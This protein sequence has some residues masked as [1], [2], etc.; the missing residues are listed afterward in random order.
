MHSCEVLRGE[1]LLAYDSAAAENEV[2]HARGHSGLLVDLHQVVVRENG[3]GR[4]LPYHGV[5]HQHGGHREVG[6]NGCEVE[7]G[8]GEDES[9]ERTVLHA[10]DLVRAALGLDAVDLGGKCCIVAQEIVSHAESISA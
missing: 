8:Q 7:R 5:A 1:D 2:Y 10:I 6:G 4:G 9:L 3:G